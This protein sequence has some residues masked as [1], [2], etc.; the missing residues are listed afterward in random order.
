MHFPFDD[1]E[2]QAIGVHEAG[3]VLSAAV[4]LPVLPCPPALIAMILGLPA[5][6]AP[7]GSGGP[8]QPQMPPK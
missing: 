2:G 7:T 4:I 8:W 6:P 5:N 3:M 1:T